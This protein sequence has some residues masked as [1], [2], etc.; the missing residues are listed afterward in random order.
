MLYVYKY[1]QGILQAVLTATASCPR[2]YTD[3]VSTD[4]V[5]K[6]GFEKT[7]QNVIKQMSTRYSDAMI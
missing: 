5:S 2:L 7:R 6:H 4:C 3:F 1:K